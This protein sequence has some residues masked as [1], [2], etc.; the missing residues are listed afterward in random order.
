LNI[1]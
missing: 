1:D